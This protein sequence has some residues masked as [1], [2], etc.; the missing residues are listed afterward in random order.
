[1]RARYQNAVF[2]TTQF[3]PPVVILEND[4]FTYNTIFKVEST[5]VIQPQAYDAQLSYY[6]QYDVGYKPFNQTFLYAV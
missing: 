1:M 3:K 5:L 4:F 6:R 2:P